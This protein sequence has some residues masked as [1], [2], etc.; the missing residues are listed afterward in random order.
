MA[1]VPVTL[2]QKGAILDTAF[3]PDI[4]MGMA[5]GNYW[6]KEDLDI[7]Y[8]ERIKYDHSYPAYFAQALSNPQESWCYPD[9]ALAEFRK[10]VKQ[11]YLTGQFPRYIESKV[12]AG[13]ITAPNANAAITA[14]NPPKLH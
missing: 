7:I 1:S 9:E 4:S 10:W 11:T 13:A 2:I 3:I 14:L 5:W 6:V 8:G 12:K